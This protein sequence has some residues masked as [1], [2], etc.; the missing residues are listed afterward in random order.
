M[1]EGR[2]AFDPA[3]ARDAAALAARLTRLDDAEARAAD[4]EE[5]LV[6]Q[7]TLLAASLTQ[8]SCKDLV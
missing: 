2:A 3:L 7:M 1:A 5:A 8:G 6:A 4:R